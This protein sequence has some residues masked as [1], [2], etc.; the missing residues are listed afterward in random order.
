MESMLASPARMGELIAA[1][2]GSYFVLGMAAMASGVLIAI[3]LF[4]VPFRGSVLV[5]TLASALF[6]VFALSLGLFISTLAR[7]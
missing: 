4:G 7:N 2:L 6:L 1:K 5:L 3:L